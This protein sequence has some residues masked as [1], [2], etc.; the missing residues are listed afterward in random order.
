MDGNPKIVWTGRGLSIL[1]SLPFLMSSVMKL[2]GHPEVA[3]GMEHLGLPESLIKP[4]GLLELS[5]AVIYL[6]PVTSVLGAV[7]L[8]GFIGGAILTHLRV[9]EAVYLHIAIGLSIWLG[10]YLREPRLRDLLPLRKRLER[11]A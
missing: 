4:L 8:T 3:K 10:L 5:C 2:V 11:R 9:G 7:L 6:V 1:V